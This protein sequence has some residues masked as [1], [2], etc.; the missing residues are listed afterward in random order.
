MGNLSMIPRVIHYCWFSGESKPVLM[1]E[2][3]KSWERLMPDYR[4]KCWDASSLDLSIPFL[5]QAYEHKSWAFLT[6]YMRFY[7]L[8]KEGGIYFDSDVEVY[9]RFDSFLKHEMFSCV[10]YEER[11]F[12][13]NGFHLIDEKGHLVDTVSLNNSFGIAI[14]AAIIGAV[15]GHPYI[16]ACL[17]YYRNISYVDNDGV[18]FRKECPVVMAEVAIPYGF[19]YKNERQELNDG[20]CLYP[21]PTFVYGEGLEEK[22]A[23]ARHW[24]NGSWRDKTEMSRVYKWLSRFH[25]E[26][27]YKQL[28]LSPFG[29]RLYRRISHIINK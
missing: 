21:F 7:I 22:G 6:D 27:L 23:Y 14:E 9:R 13:N 4:I 19:V 15:K 29:Y 12:L 17:D 11:V 2:C 8:W 26:Y 28:E 20:I 25:L 16:K 24:R 3:I 18:V 5:R 1:R 10:E